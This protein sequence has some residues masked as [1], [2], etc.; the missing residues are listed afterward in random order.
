MGKYQD[1]VVWQKSMD[2]VEEVYGVARNLPNAEKF[3]LSDQMKRAAISIPSN[4]AEGQR[5]GSIKEV[6]W[7]M[8]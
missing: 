4:I 5:R 8:S 1:L 6:Y 3:A 7:D 2:L